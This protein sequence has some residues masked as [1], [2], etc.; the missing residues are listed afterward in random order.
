ME[1]PDNRAKFKHVD[2]SAYA[3]K[4]TK[5]TRGAPPR[6]SFHVLEAT[7]PQVE[8]VVAPPPPWN[9]VP[10]PSDFEI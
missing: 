10:D 3:T 9:A 2:V 6:E 5:A 4:A 7:E 8:V 1:Y